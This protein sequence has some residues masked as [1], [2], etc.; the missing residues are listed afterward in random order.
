MQHM[1]TDALVVVVCAG[2]RVRAGRSASTASPRVS[3]ARKLSSPRSADVQRTAVG[4]VARGA[5]TQ[6]DRRQSPASRPNPLTYNR[7]KPVAAAASWRVTPGPAV[8]TSAYQPRVR[9]VLDV[10]DGMVTPVATSRGTGAPSRPE[11]G[12]PSATVSEAAFG[13]A[14]ADPRAAVED[15]DPEAAHSSPD[16]DVSRA[17][18]RQAAQVPPSPLVGTFASPTRDGAGDGASPVLHGSAWRGSN[19]VVSSVGFAPGKP[20]HAY[21]GQR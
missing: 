18:R 19:V 11:S 5:P 16:N 1:N 12:P 8:D 20:L 13:A 14:D 7:R 15:D 6:R 10:G 3:R 21:V 17:P 9:G 4:G 2:V